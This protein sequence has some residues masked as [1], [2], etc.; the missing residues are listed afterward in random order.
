M[1]VKRPLLV[2]FAGTILLVLLPACDDAGGVRD[3]V[4][5]LHEVLPANAV[6]DLLPRYPGIAVALVA[7][8]DANVE[9]RYG[10]RYVR[11]DGI[12]DEGQ[13]AEFAQYVVQLL[14]NPAL[15]AEHEAR[16]Q[17]W[18]DMSGR[19]QLE[20]VLRRMRERYEGFDYQWTS[21][22]QPGNVEAMYKDNG[23][24]IEGVDDPLMRE[25]IAVGIIQAQQKLDAEE[26][27]DG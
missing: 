11:V 21:G 27:Q 10:E 20:D 5:D 17:A 24:I 19:E 2:L 18:H 6:E 16:A 4:V 8:D 22:G 3:E 1:N 13:R 26:R 12:E 25:E 7:Q 14:E 15:K 9:V 23:I